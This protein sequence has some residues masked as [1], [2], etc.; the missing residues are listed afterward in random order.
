MAI[1]VL[2]LILFAIDSL[3]NILVSH[4]VEG[5]QLVPCKFVIIAYIECR[6]NNIVKRIIDILMKMNIKGTPGPK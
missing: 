6:K 1:V 3:K 4:P 2:L 5:S